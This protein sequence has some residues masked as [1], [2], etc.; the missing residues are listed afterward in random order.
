MTYLIGLTDTDPDVVPCRSCRTRVRWVTTTTG[1]RMP[2]D[3]GDQPDGTIVPVYAETADGTRTVR[4]RVLAGPEL[5][6]ARANHT[7][8]YRSHFATCPH[9]DTHRR[10]TATTPTP[11]HTRQ[12]LIP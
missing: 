12:E 5:A 11:D 2:L 4:A 6:T 1:Q 7:P 8:L 3:L 9:T 10:A